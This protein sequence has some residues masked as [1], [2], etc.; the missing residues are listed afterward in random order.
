MYYHTTV[1]R[2]QT[3]QEMVEVSPEDTRLAFK[4]EDIRSYLS[5]TVT[6]LQCIT[7]DIFRYHQDN[8]F[9]LIKEVCRINKNFTQRKGRN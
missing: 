4:L 1:E 5:T 7:E 9:D 3:L 6:L 2:L 8:D